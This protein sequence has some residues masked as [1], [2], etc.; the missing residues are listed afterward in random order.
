MEDW[1]RGARDDA[2]VDVDKDGPVWFVTL[3]GEHDSCA[4]KLRNVL[5]A[6]IGSCSEAITQN[7]YVVV[8]LSQV[9]FFDSSVLG[10]IVQAHRAVADD[11]DLGL[12]VVVE[13]PDCFAARLL[14][15][16]GITSEVPTF[17]SR[18]DAVAALGGPVTP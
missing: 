14:R 4:P 7:A 10:A 11:P 1:Q 13:S 18:A 2:D 9:A 12:A 5:D 8:D 15:V 16:V 3:R 17:A 6:L